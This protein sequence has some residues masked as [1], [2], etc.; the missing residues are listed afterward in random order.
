MWLNPERA[1]L[2]KALLEPVAKGGP[3]EKAA[4]ALLKQV[5]TYI[6]SED[7]RKKKEADV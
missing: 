5:E 2:L 3:A 7:Y 4:A 6:N 1:D